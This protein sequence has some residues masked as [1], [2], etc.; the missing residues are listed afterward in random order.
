MK[1][2]ILALV[3][4]AKS[5][6]GFPSYIPAFL[7]RMKQHFVSWKNRLVNIL[8]DILDQSI[9]WIDLN[10]LKIVGAFM[11]HTKINS[12]ESDS[13]CDTTI[14]H[15]SSTLSLRAFTS[16]LVSETRLAI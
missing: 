7:W 16:S 3:V 2:L 8:L 12:R 14:F 9:L 6:C 11:C 5:I 1:K 10:I 13:L 4:L 15:W